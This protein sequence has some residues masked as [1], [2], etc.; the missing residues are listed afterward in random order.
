MTKLRSYE[1]SVLGGQELIW[2][3]AEVKCSHNTY[4]FEI[5]KAIDY[6]AVYFIDEAQRR[7]SIAN[8]EEMLMMIPNEVIQKRYR[9]IVGDAEWLLLDGIYDF[10][11]MTEEEVEAF[12]YLKEDVLDEMESSL[13]I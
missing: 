8:I 5:Y 10:R 11:S 12:L 2:H 6:I 9:N 7:F 1:I 4:R 3:I 13:D